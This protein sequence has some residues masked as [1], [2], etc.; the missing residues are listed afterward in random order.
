[1]TAVLPAGEQEVTKIALQQMMRRKTLKRL[2]AM[3]MAIYLSGRINKQCT[4]L[5]KTPLLENSLL[6]RFMNCNKQAV[7]IKYFEKPW[8]SS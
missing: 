8:F 2:Y 7:L 6:E 4:L 3:Y 5:R 1:V